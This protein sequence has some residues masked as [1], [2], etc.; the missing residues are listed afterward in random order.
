MSSLTYKQLLAGNRSFRRLLAGQVVS[1]LG[2]WFNFIAGL[3]LVRAVS[4]ASPEVLAILIVLRLLP[5]G[6]FAPLAGAF[7]DRFSRRRVM[8]WTDALRAVFALGFLFVRGPEDLWIAYACTLIS[9]L[10]SAFFEGAKNAALPNV[11]GERGLLAGNALMF[12]SRFLLMSIGSALGGLA[13]AQF[14]YNV[15]FVINALSFIVSAYSIWLIPEEDLTAQNSALASTE[16]NALATGEGSRRRGVFA[17]YLSDVT[18]G[19]R[20]ILRTPLVAAIIGINIMWAIGGGGLNLVYER[21]GAVVFAGES[22]WQPDAAVSFLYTAV[23][24]GLFLGMALARR[25]GSKVELRGVTPAFM[26]WTLIAHGVLFALAGVM[27]TIWLTALMMFLSRVIIGVEFAVQETLL[28]R[29]MP[30][31][32]RGRVSTTDRAAEILVMSATRL[33]AGWMLGFILTPRSLTVLS[34]LLSAIPGVVWLALFASGKLRM[35]ARLS[36]DREATEEKTA[37]A[38]AG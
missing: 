37:L 13:A 14:G 31:N 7:V 17:G 30:D 11:V 27:P 38:S 12:S 5:F 36:S 20:F 35:P 16:P 22:G 24:A 34:G 23:G 10:L 21:L 9:T 28:M 15:A 26:G 33:V 1:E 25:V 18:E 19:W 32:L 29:L 4:G 6:L 8:I 3:G 2:N